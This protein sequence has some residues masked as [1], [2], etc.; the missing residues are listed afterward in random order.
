MHQAEPAEPAEPAQYVFEWM[1]GW[2]LRATVS[3]Q[4]LGTD[5][6]DC[7]LDAMPEILDSVV[8]HL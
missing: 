2:M 3:L 8:L 1:D 4:T 5:N 7:C 6:M